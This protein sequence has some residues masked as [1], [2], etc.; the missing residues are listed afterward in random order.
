MPLA[1]GSHLGTFEILGPLGAGGM[2]EVYRARDSRLEREVAIKVL[3][4]RLAGDSGGIARF[5]REARLLAALNHPGIATI[6]GAEGTAEER[7]I[8][9]ELVPGETLKER[10][11]RGPLPLLEA[12]EVARQ[13]ADALAAAHERGIVH[14]DLKPSNVKV[15]PGGKVKVLDFGLAKAQSAL[16]DPDATESPTGLA[17]DATE[18]GMILGTPEYMSPEQ[19]RGRPLDRRT[20][21]WSFGCILFEMLTGRR[22]F[23]G[24]TPPDALAAILTREPGWE[25]LPA[26]T[27]QR[28]HDLLERCL[29]KDPERR[30]RDAADARWELE[31]ELPEA[32]SSTHGRSR[33]GATPGR[34]RALS[35]ALVVAA[36]AALLLAGAAAWLVRRPAAAPEPAATPPAAATPSLVVLPSRDLSGL[37]GGQLVG[38]ALVETLS[39]RLGQLPAFHVV[40]PAA[41]VAAAD[42]FSDPLAAARSVGARLAVRSSIMRSGQAVRIAYEV[43]SVDG[44]RQVASGTVDGRD[45]DLFGLQDRF[46]ASVAEALAADPA[47]AV[48]RPTAHGGLDSAAS[49]E[50]YLQAIGSL[51]RADRADELARAVTLLEDLAA[52]HPDSPLV[53][54]ALGRAY[55][56]RLNL[57]KDPAWAAR[58]V[59]AAETARRLDPAVAEVDVTLGQTRLATG[60]VAEAEA[61]FRRALS[62]DPGNAG[63]LVGLG[64]SR[65]AA[66]DAAGA[67]AAFERA[68]ALHPYDFDPYNQLGA[69]LFAAGRYRDAATVFRSLTELAPDSYRAFN[70]LGGALTMSCDFAAAGK[71]YGR[72]LELG[73]KH[74]A[75]MTNLG[76]NELWTGKAARAV[77]TLERAAEALPGDYGTWANLGDAY[78]AAGRAAEARRAYERAIELARAELRLN[79]GHPA[80]HAFLATSLA[81][82]GRVAEAEEPMR[83]ALDA[84]GGDP[85]VLLD[86]A[87][88]A[89]LGGRRDE[90][91]A[92]AGRAVAAGYC[93]AVVAAS[94]DL[95]QLRADPRFRAL[96]SA[97]QG[98]AGSSVPS[99]GR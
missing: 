98:A 26:S 58:A 37:P 16:G 72:A 49:Q 41:A 62:T 84:G 95:A 28:I 96:V 35:P 81:R 12:L 74:V 89:A 48:P 1:A 47:Q 83:R 20:D 78:R 67:E 64:R 38:D 27:P 45:A 29:E 46:A 34:R 31:R 19:A 50:S 70:N 2:G 86:A 68:V 73:P 24:A 63:A 33:S 54:A 52:Q 15:T 88:V 82:T 51:Q 60:H 56:A 85:R 90:A 3:P 18:P 14:R 9:L 65:E 55:L 76:M 13:I 36:L 32:A 99:T 92:L 79:A 4:A 71:A 17:P 43:L 22:P 69:F 42:R 7:Y 11:Q 75:A 39:A 44:G 6:Y 53:F 21:I 93:P 10:L 66:G 80:A 30:L 40:T 61:A 59:E 25:A 8:V 5:E 91:I 87:A 97:P 23:G 77:A 94:P 57:T